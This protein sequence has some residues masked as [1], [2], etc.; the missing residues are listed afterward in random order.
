LGIA[1]SISATNG[2][3]VEVNSTIAA[4]TI[5][6]NNVITRLSID[7]AQSPVAIDGAGQLTGDVSAPVPSKKEKGYD[8]NMLAYSD[9][10]GEWFEQAA[11]FEQWAIGR[12]VDEVVNMR[13]YARD[14]AHPAV[15]DE[16][17]LTASVT[18]SVGEFIDA[19]RKAAE[20]ANGRDFSLEGDYQTGLGIVTMTS[21]SRSAT[22]ETAGQVQVTSNA[23][24]VTTDSA[25]KIVSLFLDNAYSTV[26][27]DT[28]GVASVPG[29]PY[30]SKWEMRELYG[31]K[32]DYGSQLGEWYEQAEG[33]N[34]WSV[35]KTIAE[36]VGTPT[37]ARD[38]AHPAVPTDPD[39]TA[40]TTISIGDIL[41]AVQAAGNNLQ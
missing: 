18:I 24:A 21:S 20:N 34:A 3:N 29:A 32:A 41:K 5:D 35:G 11:A 38:D 19:V 6:Q 39:L 36:V 8:Y 2:S 13:T 26:P 33:F 17:D 10:I 37:V 15:P 31:M 12:T 27:V 23:V 25:G 16:P 14:D 7:A 9:A 1:T 40:S 4:I 30:L 28:S 22:A